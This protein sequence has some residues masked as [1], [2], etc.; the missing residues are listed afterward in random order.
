MK[1]DGEAEKKPDDKARAIPAAGPS[2]ASHPPQAVLRGE[3]PPSF[4]HPP[5]PLP[6]SALVG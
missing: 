6:P 2:A 1:K 3:T 5:P 4:T